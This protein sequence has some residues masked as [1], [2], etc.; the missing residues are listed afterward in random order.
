MNKLL[1]IIII[2]LF[3]VS[4]LLIFSYINSNKSIKQESI[5]NDSIKP[6]PIK[7]ELQKP[8]IPVVLGDYDFEIRN[9]SGHVDID[10]LITQLNNASINT[11]AFLIWHRATDYGDLISFL[12]AAEKAGIDVWAYLVPP[13]EPPSSEPFSTDYINWSASLARTSLYYPNLK[14]MVIDDFN[15]NLNFFTPEYIREMRNA[16]RSVNPEFKFM[17]I[18]YYPS[19]NDDLTMLHEEYIDGVIFPYMNWPENNVSNVNSTASELR[20][21]RSASQRLKG[22]FSP[23]TFYSMTF[24]PN[25]P[26]RPGDFAE[27]TQTF[28]VPADTLN[29]VLIFKVRD[30]HITTEN[31]RTKGYLFKQALIEDKVAWEDDVGGDEGN[32]AVSI[33]LKEFVSNRTRANLTLRVYFKKSV[34]NLPV[35]VWWSNVSITNVSLY[36]PDFKGADGWTFSKNNSHW[37]GNYTEI[38][39]NNLSLIVMIYASGFGSERATAEY[40]RDAMMIAHTAAEEGN[41]DGIMIY[42]LNKMS[43]NDRYLLVK[44]LYSNWSKAYK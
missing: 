4:L 25:A 5:K 1:K 3:V 36:N 7:Q 37:K 42:G 29:P 30:D 40:L 19:I 16:S 11:Y 22:N 35:T 8:K 32:L 31:E 17:P 21:I 34:S 14:G 26:S 27:I 2:L 13:S 9:S 20:Q 39:P 12:P 23:N 6:V 24:T 41:A 18:M 44:E 43:A 28:K 15:L 38:K 33:G 10:K